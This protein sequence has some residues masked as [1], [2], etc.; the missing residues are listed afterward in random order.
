M[1]D[2]YTAVGAAHKASSDATRPMI[3][4][5]DQGGNVVAEQVAICTGAMMAGG[6]G[7]VAAA[8]TPQSLFGGATPMNGYEVVNCDATAVLWIND[9]G[10]GA[11]VGAAGS[12]PIQPYGRYTTPVTATP[13]KG[14]T[15]ASATVG[16]VFTARKW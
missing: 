3:R 1:A 11:A 2:V 14:V 8:N 13:P 7:N 15:V 6:S 9:E 5:V 12:I 4:Y 16:H 10:G